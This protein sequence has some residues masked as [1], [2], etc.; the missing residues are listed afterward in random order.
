MKTALLV[1]GNDHPAHKWQETTPI[2]KSVF[3][4]DS[5]IKVTVTEDPEDLQTVSKDK[6][7]FIILNYCNWEDSAGISEKAKKGFLAY[8]EE[9]GGLIVLHFSNGAFHFSLPGAGE[10]DWPEYRKIVH[11]VWDHNGGSTHDPYG[12]FKVKMNDIEHYITKELSGFDTQD[13]LYYNQV[14]E[15]ELPALYSA[16]SAQSGKAEPLAWAY[17]YKN[18]RVFQSLL[19][20]G[21]ES[22]DPQEYQE[23]LRRAASW[24]TE[25]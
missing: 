6:Y 12:A 23:I 20:H 22:Y 11:Q 18:S 5:L 1:T 15:T 3:E 14:G 13:E 16:V 2:I 24:V 7:D 10:S 17:T 21:P 4:K 25:L 9:G 8:L 19:G